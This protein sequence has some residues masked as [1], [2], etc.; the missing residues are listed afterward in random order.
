[1]FLR[2]ETEIVSAC[3]FIIHIIVNNGQIL[4]TAI[5]G[6]YKYPVSFAINNY[7]VF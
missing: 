1:M 5:H 3:M 4:S 6:I 2:T 7:F